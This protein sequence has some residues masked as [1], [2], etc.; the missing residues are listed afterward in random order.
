MKSTSNQRFV[1]DDTTSP[2]PI[3]KLSEF[4][5]EGELRFILSKTLANVVDFMLNLKENYEHFFHA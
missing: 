5:R 3:F 1:M 2:F 4:G